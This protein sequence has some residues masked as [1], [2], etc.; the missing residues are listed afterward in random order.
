[1]LNK[2]RDGKTHR[3][4]VKSWLVYSVENIADTRTNILRIHQKNGAILVL[5]AREYTFNRY[6]HLWT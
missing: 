6:H 1:M 3:Y 4:K 5:V 2:G